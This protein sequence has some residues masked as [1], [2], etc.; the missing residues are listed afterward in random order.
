MAQIKQAKDV[1]PYSI[2]IVDGH[3]PCALGSIGMGE[4]FRAA[5]YYTRISDGERFARYYR[6]YDEVKIVSEPIDGDD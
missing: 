2:I 6:E 3:G 5:F 1:R 4:P